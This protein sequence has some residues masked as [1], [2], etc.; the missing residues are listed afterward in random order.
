MLEGGFV[1]TV[2]RSFRA[3][4]MGQPIFGRGIQVCCRRQQPVCLSGV[5]HRCF[6]VFHSLITGL[7]LTLLTVAGAVWLPVQ[8]VQLRG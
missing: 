3:F 6:A 2:G 1:V 7:L 8:P 4:S 5:W